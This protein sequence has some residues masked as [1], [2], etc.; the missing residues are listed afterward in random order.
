MR[1]GTPIYIFKL[2][3][4]N[5]YIYLFKILHM[6]RTHVQ[7]RILPV[8][9][10]LTKVII[11]HTEFGNGK[12][13]ITYGIIFQKMQMIPLRTFVQKAK[14]RRLLLVYMDSCKCLVYLCFIL[15]DII[16]NFKLFFKPTLLNFQEIHITFID[17]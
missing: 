5:V 7:R 15:T 9:W 2:Q 13:M 8:L 1:V 3:L 17:K 12:H 11:P 4:I 6:K 14:G 10:L 16:A